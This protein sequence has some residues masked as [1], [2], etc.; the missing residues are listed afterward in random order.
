MFN[1]FSVRLAMKLTKICSEYDES[2]VNV[3]HMKSD[4]DD[5]SL[6]GN[7]ESL[8]MAFN[9]YFS[10]MGDT[11]FPGMSYSDVINEIKGVK[12][13]SKDEAR[14][15]LEKYK[16]STGYFSGGL[17]MADMERMLRDMTFGKAETNVILAALVLAGA[18]FT[19][20]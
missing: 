9:T 10:C 20:E 3:A 18:K 7:Q 13:A 1:Q 15:T 8:I 11:I 17:N 14:L 6:T 12:Y 19:I 5:W 2:D 16:N 4:L